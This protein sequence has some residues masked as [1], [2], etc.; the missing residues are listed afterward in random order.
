MQRAANEEAQER[1][2]NGI[3]LIK[4]FEKFLCI[5]I[6]DIP[7]VVIARGSLEIGFGQFD[8]VNDLRLAIPGSGLE[9]GEELEDGTAGLERIVAPGA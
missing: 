9:F 2:F 7:G 4:T 8:G 1:A 6:A 5:R 3:P